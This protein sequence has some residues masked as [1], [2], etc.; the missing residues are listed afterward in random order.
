MEFV[1]ALTDLG[2]R[3]QQRRVSTCCWPTVT[4]ERSPSAAIEQ[5]SVQRWEKSAWRWKVIQGGNRE[6]VNQGIEAVVAAEVG[7][8][9]RSGAATTARRAGRI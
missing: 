1:L 8:F 7:I 3:S 2:H 9:P 6:R 5:K 4:R